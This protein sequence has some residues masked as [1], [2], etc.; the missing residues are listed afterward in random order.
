MQVGFIYQSKHEAVRTLKITLV[1]QSLHFWRARWVIWGRVGDGRL[2]AFAV[3]GHR[4]FFHPHNQVECITAATTQRCT[5]VRKSVTTHSAWPKNKRSIH[6]RST[7][8]TDD[9]KLNY[10]F[11][12]PLL[13]FVFC[14][15]TCPIIINRI[16]FWVSVRPIIKF[17][18]IIKYE[19]WNV[20]IIQIKILSFWIFDFWKLSP[21]SS[22]CSKCSKVFWH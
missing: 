10:I 11:K 22:K 8:Y 12:A 21:K 15:Y 20:Y 7:T 13:K 6:V 3:P 16:R 17:T 18:K 9:F 5:C 2:G 19:L 14:V 1:L 4:F